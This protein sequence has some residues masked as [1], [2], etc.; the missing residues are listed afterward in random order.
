MI[1]TPHLWL[2]KV[3]DTFVITKYDKIEML[4]ELMFNC[5][6]QFTY[7]RATNNTLPFLEL[8]KRDNEGRLQTE[9]YLYWK[10]THTKQY[11]DYTSNQPEHVKVGTIKTLVMMNLM[12]S[13]KQCG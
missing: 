8:I 10:K 9:V 4:H 1:H 5:K 12:A 3:D 6:V 11:M 7:G 13:K 2:R